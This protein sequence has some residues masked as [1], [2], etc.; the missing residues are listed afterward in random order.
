MKV[1]GKIDYGCPGNEWTL[2]YFRKAGFPAKSAVKMFQAG[3]HCKKMNFIEIKTSSMRTTAYRHIYYISK[4]PEIGS[5]HF[6]GF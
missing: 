3:W 5:D 1:A 4:K 2:N 6:G